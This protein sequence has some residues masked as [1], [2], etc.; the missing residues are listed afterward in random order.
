MFANVTH[1]STVA[2]LTR[3]IREKNTG[4]PFKRCPQKP[5]IKVPQPCS[6]QY[7]KTYVMYI[8]TILNN[9]A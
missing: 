2:L 6:A 3:N 4:L 1:S 9:I 7:D 8:I 5:V